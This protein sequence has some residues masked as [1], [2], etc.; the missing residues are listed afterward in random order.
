M[1]PTDP[2]PSRGIAAGAG[3]VY[4]PGIEA[5]VGVGTGYGASSVM[6]CSCSLVYVLFTTYSSPCPWSN[7]KIDCKKSRSASESGLVCTLPSADWDWD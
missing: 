6:A 3:G 5:G 1:I 2:W 4:W 7:S